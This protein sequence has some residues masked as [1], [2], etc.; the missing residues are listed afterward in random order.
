M[1]GKASG[2]ADQDCLPSSLYP[3]LVCIFQAWVLSKATGIAART[4][5]SSASGFALKPR[6]M[7]LR[8]QKDATFVA[9]ATVAPQGGEEPDAE[10]SVLVLAAGGKLGL[11]P[12]GGKDFERVKDLKVTLKIDCMPG[13]LQACL[14][15]VW[16]QEYWQSGEISFE[17]GG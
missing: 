13:M 2:V 7:A 8:S 9:A 4:R 12:A 17:W 3:G 11:L 15:N 1:L 5:P 14:T 16:Q 10:V 6:A